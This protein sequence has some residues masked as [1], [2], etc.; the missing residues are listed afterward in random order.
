MKHQPQVETASGATT[1]MSMAARPDLSG[2]LG[3]LNRR[4]LLAATIRSIR[5]NGFSGKMEIIVVDGGSTDGTCEWLARQVDILT[6]IQPNYKVRSPNG[7][8]RRAHTWGEFMNLGFRRAIAPWILMVSDDLL[9][10]PGCIQAGLDQIQTAS[11]SGRMLGGGAMFYRDYPRNSSYHVKL[12]PGGVVHINHGFYSKAALESV[13]Y[14]D[15]SRFEFYG[16]DGELTMRLNREGFRTVALE[17]SFAEHLAHTPRLLRW[18][19]KSRDPN[20]E[21]DMRM[22]ESLFGSQQAGQE[23]MT[24][25]NHAD[26]NGTARQFWLRCPTQASVAFAA[27]IIERLV[28]ALA[29]R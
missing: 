14:A 28:G 7:G 1:A 17:G 21:A 12:L 18:L 19:S 3:S 11:V 16:A 2:V 15:E 4:R 27:S 24:Q 8:L 26:P 13:G 23:I 20:V 9:L 22:F 25:R 10:C 5:E 6:I 29:H